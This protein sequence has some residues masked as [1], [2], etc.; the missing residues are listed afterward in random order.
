MREDGGG[1]GCNFMVKCPLEL[2]RLMLNH[3]GHFLK[4]MGQEI[5]W[6]KFKIS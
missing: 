3:A 1:I 5:S 2:Y 4:K 6:G